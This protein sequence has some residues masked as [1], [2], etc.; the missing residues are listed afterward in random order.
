MTWKVNVAII[1]RRTWM[2]L[3][4][5]QLGKRPVRRPRRIWEDNIKIDLTVIWTGFI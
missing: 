5:N 3:V 2:I 1:G 4:R